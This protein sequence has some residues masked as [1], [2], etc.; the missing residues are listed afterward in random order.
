MLLKCHWHV[1][2]CFLPFVVEFH[3]QQILDVDLCCVIYNKS[4]EIL[5]EKNLSSKQ[6]KQNS[7]ISISQKI[8]YNY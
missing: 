1:W 7:I 8:V 6:K 4:G 3:L 2:S 5:K